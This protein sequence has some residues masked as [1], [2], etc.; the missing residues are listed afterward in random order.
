MVVTNNEIFDFLVIGAGSAGVAVMSQLTKISKKK[1]I[2]WIDKE[3]NGGYIS[4]LPHVPSNTTVELFLR[5]AREIEGMESTAIYREMA[6]LRQ[7]RGC[8][9]VLV[10]EML[11]YAVKYLKEFPF[12]N[13]INDECTK[14]EKPN[15]NHVWSVETKNQKIFLAKRVFLC[16]G[17]YSKSFS[18]N[19]CYPIEMALNGEFPPN[20]NSA[21][22]IGSSHSAMLVVMNLVK[23]YGI[24]KLH[25]FFHTTSKLRFAQR[26][27]PDRSDVFINDN[28]GLKGEVADWC[29]EHQSE[30]ESES[31]VQIN[32]T[33]F[34]SFPST[35]LEKIKICDLIISAT[36]Y[37]RNDLPVII[38]GR[39]L[40]FNNTGGILAEGLYGF[41]IAF[42]ET[43][44]DCDTGRPERAVGLWKCMKFVKKTIDTNEVDFDIVK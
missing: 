38:D 9:L 15:Q 22:V 32:R 14:I 17:S 43:V 44:H 35:A 13:C 41:G 5:F 30:L 24:P 16:I 36:G 23:F 19:H 25:L 12:L 4:K 37:E 10:H 8:K 40:S 20:L 7:D 42:P 34:Q 33:R 21:A 1:R 27:F 26:K 29:L 2:L 3:W 6:R 31:E 11:L 28:T 39:E 18:E